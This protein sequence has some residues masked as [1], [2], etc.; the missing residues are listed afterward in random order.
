MKRVYYVMIVLAI[1]IMKVMMLRFIMLKLG[2]AAI[3]VMPMRGI[4]RGEF[5]IFALLSLF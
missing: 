5:I 4:Q 1:P 2:V 3:A